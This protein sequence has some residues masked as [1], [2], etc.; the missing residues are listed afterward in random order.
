MSGWRKLGR[1]FGR[2]DPRK[3]VVRMNTA[4]WT[5]LVVV[6]IVCVVATIVLRHLSGVVADRKT[7]KII[8][9]GM[10]EQSEDGKEGDK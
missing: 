10:S 4:V 9:E 6:V 3:V 2:R 8:I 1:Y 7:R 5:L